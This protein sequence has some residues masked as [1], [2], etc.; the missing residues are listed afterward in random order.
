[1]AKYQSQ[2]RHIV[3]GRKANVGRGLLTESTPVPLSADV[4]G[5]FVQG[6]LVSPN[7][8]SLSSAPRPKAKTLDCTV[9]HSVGTT[10]PRINRRLLACIHD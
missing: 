6:R 9:T 8:L 4:L 2:D 3:L 10:I 1:M 7:L 5:C